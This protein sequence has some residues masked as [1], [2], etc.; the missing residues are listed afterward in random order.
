MNLYCNEKI[1]S[2][3]NSLFN[4]AFAQVINNNKYKEINY[5]QKLNIS[6]SNEKQFRW[7]TF[8]HRC[9]LNHR[10]IFQ[11]RKNLK[12]YNFFNGNHSYR[13][14]VEDRYGS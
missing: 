13:V 10:E 1:L 12:V 4:I 2:S 6:W 8:R 9:F 11:T 3:P 7:K 5:I 14:K